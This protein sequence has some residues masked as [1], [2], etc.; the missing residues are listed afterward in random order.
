M[1]RLHTAYDLDKRRGRQLAFCGMA[2]NQPLVFH[3]VTESWLQCPPPEILH[4]CG[5]PFDESQLF[6]ND[7]IPRFFRTCAAAGFEP[8]CGAKLPRYTG[9]YNVWPGI[10]RPGFKKSKRQVAEDLDNIETLLEEVFELAEHELDPDVVLNQLHRI[11]GLKGTASLEFYST[12]VTVGLL[13]SETA[14]RNSF[15]AKLDIDSEQHKYLK[16][17]YQLQT[18]RQAEQLLNRMAESLQ[19]YLKDADN[20]LCE[21]RRFKKGRGK[22]DFFIREQDIYHRYIEHWINEKNENCEKV[23]MK[24]KTRGGIDWVEHSPPVWRDASAATTS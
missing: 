20:G 14:R 19:C 2:I 18:N 9:N 8:G 12:A 11:R 10:W 22:F 13:R 6:Q 15:F 16:E 4:D 1:L 24:K 21:G 5:R 7:L 17:Q 3:F 23:L